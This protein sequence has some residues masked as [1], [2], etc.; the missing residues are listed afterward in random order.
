MDTV[1][2][3]LLISSTV[4][5]VC[6]IAAILKM[7]T[8]SNEEKAN[9]L[10]IVNHIKA[11]DNSVDE[12]YRTIEEL[13]EISQSVFTEIENKYQ[14]LL[15]LFNLVDEKKKEVMQLY[16]DTAVKHTESTA[17][18]STERKQL[19]ITNPRHVEIMEMFSK[20]ISIADISKQLSMGQGEV[21][22]IVGLYK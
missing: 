8:H 16:S 20:G 14:E 3:L 9:S 1:H 5:I 10:E 13:N 2:I 15:F 4:G 12:A 22:L 17:K 19:K 21:K 18:I 6:I 11:I 7:R